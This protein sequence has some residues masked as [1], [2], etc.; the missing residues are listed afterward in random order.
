MKLSAGPV[1]RLTN[2]PLPRSA[3]PVVALPGGHEHEHP[4]LAGA[5]VVRLHRRPDL[6]DAAA[7]GVGPWVVIFTVMVANN[8]WLYPQQSVLYQAAYDATGERSFSHR[9]AR[10]LAVAY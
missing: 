8:L 1:A 6:Q 4:A 7:A 2:R 10:P 5:L 9:Q 3:E